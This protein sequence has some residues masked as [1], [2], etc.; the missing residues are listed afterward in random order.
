MVELSAGLITRH[1]KKTGRTACR[2]ARRHDAQTPIAEFGEKI[3]YM[4][5]KNMSKSAPKVE[6]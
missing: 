3:M 5:S 6:G 2:E 1:G 4:T